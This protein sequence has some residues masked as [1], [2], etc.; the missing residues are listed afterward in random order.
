MILSRSPQQDAALDAA[1]RNHLSTQSLYFLLAKPLVPAGF[2][3]RYYS[4]TLALCAARWT[5]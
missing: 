4:K 5:N 2:V 1:M 3:D